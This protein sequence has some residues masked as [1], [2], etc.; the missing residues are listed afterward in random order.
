MR[1]RVVG[2]LRQAM[3]EGV[4][5]PG[6]RLVERDVAERLGV[7]RSPVR[8][9]I[10]LLTFE[11]FLVAE[12]PRRI[13]VRAFSRSDVDDLYDVRETL[14][15]LT[16][17]LAVRNA[18]NEDVARLREHLEQTRL[19]VD[20]DVL[21]RLSNEFHEVLTDVADNSVLSGLVAP[22]RGR[23]RWLLQQNADFARLLDEHTRIVDLIEARDEEAA[24]AFA[25]EHVRH[26]RAKAMTALFPEESET[27]E[28]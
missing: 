12:S 19:A 24:R 2:E 8:E 13:V 20:E 25:L 4:L 15:E 6:D 5:R 11:G 17:G 21:H 22:L 28:P 18:T 1:E 27:D 16:T 7:S 3:I 9:A 26:S 14:E 23:M 10:R